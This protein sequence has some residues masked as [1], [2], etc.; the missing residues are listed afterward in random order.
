MEKIDYAR[1]N[2]YRD[3]KALRCSEQVNSRLIIIIA[4]IPIQNVNVAVIRFPFFGELARG[5]AD[6]DVASVTTVSG[7]HAPTG[8]ICWGDLIFEENFDKFDLKKMAT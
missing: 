5:N 6:C 1:W 3:P 4:R 8:K 2:N 7:T